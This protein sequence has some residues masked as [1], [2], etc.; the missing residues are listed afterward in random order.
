MIKIAF[1]IN[2]KRININIVKY[3]A[4]NFK[5]MANY[6]YDI[7]G[8]FTYKEKYNYNADVL[9]VYGSENKIVTDTPILSIPY[10]HY[11]M[12]KE[13]YA[14]IKSDL[15]FLGNDIIDCIAVL[16]YTIIDNSYSI[17]KSNN[18][19]RL[20]IDLI[21]NIFFD[22]SLMR[23]YIYENMGKAVDSSFNKLKIPK[24]IIQQPVVNI[25]YSIIE[26]LINELSKKSTSKVDKSFRISCTHDVD[27]IKKTLLIRGKQ[28]AFLLYNSLKSVIEKDRNKCLLYFKK[29]INMLFRKTEYWMID[30]ITKLSEK[31]NLQPIFFIYSSKARNNIKLSNY[32]I[33][34]QYNIRN[35]KVIEKFKKSVGDFEVGLHGSYEGYNNVEYL[36]EE[37]DILEHALDRKVLWN[38]NH[39]LRFS[40]NKS[41]KTMEF[42]ELQ[43]DSTVG[44]NDIIGFRSGT[45]TPYYPYNFDTEK[46]YNIIEYPLIIMDS[47]LFNYL[48]LDKEQAFE[49]CMQ[50]IAWVRLYRGTLTLNWHNRVFSE[51]FNW[52]LLLEKLLG[53]IKL[54]KD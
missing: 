43:Y 4:K 1:I 26:N 17:D 44:F 15:N 52:N 35:K 6:N 22:L 19:Y 47:A 10:V 37:K 8:V 25:Y 38:R 29:A 41:F 14:F 20:S 46:A 50:I 16:D 28:G 34:P 7:V 39:W 21:W 45:C 51:D 5:L 33:N 3:I 49:E 2:D 31:Y 27:A 30:D 23:E 53:V 32:I 36:K 24:E 40:V 48:R 54:E 12:Q 11:N 13:K 18:N 42:V 9:I